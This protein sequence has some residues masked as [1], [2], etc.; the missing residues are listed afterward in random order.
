MAVPSTKATLKEYCLRALG[1][2]VIDINVDDDQVD[3]RIDEAVQ[4]FAQYHT[5]GVERMYLKYKVTAADKIRLRK[6]KDFNVIEKG[7]YADNI[8][9]ETGTNTVLEGKG[10]LIK[11]DGTPIH[12]ED[13][14]IVETAYQE[15]QNYLVIPDAVIS[16]INIFPLSD[17]ANLNMFDV[18]YQLRL[19]DLYD[20]SST[21]IVHYGLTMK[22]LDFLD[23]ILVGEKPMRFNQLSNR[24]YIDQDWV[25]D[26]TADEYIII[27]CYRKLDP[28]AHTDIFDDLYLKRYA[29]TLIKRQWGQNLSKFSGTAML[30]GVTLN[31]PE[32]FS[33]ALT[34][35][36]SLEEEIRLNYEEPPHFQQG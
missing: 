13:S 25:N 9:L 4:Y 12:T 18:R 28:D 1:K 24:L 31:G 5:D 35:Q 32:L 30:G 29:T 23:H 21:S 20:F 8:E 36:Q 11:E 3:D 19:N 16:V 2:P 14:T 17:R 26:V 6:N 33:T 27:E 22:H 34:E 15:T 10:D 7:T